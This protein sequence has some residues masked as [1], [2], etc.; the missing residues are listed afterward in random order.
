MTQQVIYVPGFGDESIPL[1]FG[2]VI[3]LKFWWLIGVKSQY[4]RFSW[5]NTEGFDAKLQ[6]LVDKIDSLSKNGDKVSLVGLSASASAVLNAYAQRKNIN[7]VVC[8]VGKIQNPQAIHP[9]WFKKHPDF[10]DSA[11]MVSDSLASLD[12]K[13][14]SRILS[15]RPVYDQIVPV[16][17]A[18]IPGAKNLVFPVRGHIF[19]IYF[20]IAFR[21]RT[22]TKF[23]KN[24]GI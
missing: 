6:R 12:A 11:F 23:I 1:W 4:F 16:A 9:I 19:T 5:D 15:I 21:A 17:D 3:I 13:R 10:K 20:S 18:V 7:A 14:L 24:P 2:Q 8:I 22:I